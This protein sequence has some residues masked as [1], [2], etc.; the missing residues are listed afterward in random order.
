M[1]RKRLITRHTLTDK[2]EANKLMPKKDVA[3]KEER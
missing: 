2:T 1:K 3:E